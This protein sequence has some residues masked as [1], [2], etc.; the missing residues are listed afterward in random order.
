M[1]HKKPPAGSG[2]AQ[3]IGAV[4]AISAPTGSAG[5]PADGF[6]TILS[7]IIKLDRIAEF[8]TDA[9][10]VVGELFFQKTVPRTRGDEPGEDRRPY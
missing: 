8:L 1:K 7:K 5:P 4:A 3:S 9:V 6:W 2:E 10:Q